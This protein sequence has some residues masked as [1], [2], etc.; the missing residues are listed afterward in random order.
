MNIITK[1]DSVI[2]TGLFFIVLGIMADEQ[3]FISGNLRILVG[4]VVI[5]VGIG[6]KLFENKSDDKRKD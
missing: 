4:I 2:A 5:C 1:R 3:S 6:M